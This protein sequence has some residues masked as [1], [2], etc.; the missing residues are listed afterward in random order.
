MVKKI[1]LN[2]DIEQVNLVLEGLG[3]LPS[4]RVHELIGDVHKQAAA[5]MSEGAGSMEEATPERSNVV[6]LGQE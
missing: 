4:V 2:L 3:N 1:T 6:G 5:Q